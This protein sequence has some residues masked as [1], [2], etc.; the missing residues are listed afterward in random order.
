MSTWSSTSKGNKYT[1]YLF[2]GLD[3]VCKVVARVCEPLHQSERAVI[4]P[5]HDVINLERLKLGGAWTG[6]AS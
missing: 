5:A 4:V 1:T 3:K 6:K 2:R